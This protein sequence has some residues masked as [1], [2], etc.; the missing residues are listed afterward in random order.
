MN[1]FAAVDLFCG[2]GGLS[3]GLKSAGIP[4]VAGVDIDESCRF[5]YEANVKAPFLK[6]DVAALVP[7]KLKAMYPEKGLKVLVGCAPCQPFSK[8][9]QKQR[10]RQNDHK[11][12][13]LD[14]FGRLAAEVLPDIISMENVPELERTDVF[15]RFVSRLYRL[16]Y[17]VSWNSVDCE[18]YG[19]PQTRKRLVLLASQLGPLT[20]IKPTHTGKRKLTVYDV[21]GR[22]KK[23][24][25]NDLLDR[26]MRLTPINLDRIQHSKPG[27]TWRDWP[28]H[29]KLECHKRESGRSYPAV[30]G[31]MEWHAPA[32]TI[33]TQFYLYGTGRFGHPSEDR[34]LTLR[35]GALLQTFPANYRFLP[36]TKQPSFTVQGR[37]I[38]NAV[39]PR[40]G[41]A[42]G[43][44]II[45]HLE[46]H[47]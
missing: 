5:P 10:D 22:R 18:S 2:V 16:D 3:F 11:W 43:K 8:H 9:A 25:K 32:P 46:A 35:E 14:H 24:S 28:E 7:A 42:I 44:S 17:F 13:M 47:S 40:L 41:V 19:V 31:R 38:G 23:V 29:L 36:D 45:K 15:R 1:H 33:T 21:I 34:A 39:P 26:S 37:Q 27:G 20:M 12:R 4:I 6:T 30:Y